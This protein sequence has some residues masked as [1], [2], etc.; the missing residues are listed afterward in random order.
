[1]TNP[2]IRGIIFDLDGVI[3]DTARLHYQSWLRLA[4]EENVP[5]TWET[6][7][8]MSGTTRENNLRV[9]TQGLAL[10]DATK[11]RWFE[12]KN[13]YFV[14]MMH[15]LRPGDALPGVERIMQQARAA[16]L[17]IGVGSSSRNALP[18]LRLLGLLDQFDVIGD[19][20]SVERS[21]PAPDIFLWVAGA[22]G[23]PPRHVL[24]LEDAP[25]GVE[26]ARTGGFYVIGLG[27]VPL[28]DAHA[29]L[30]GLAD[31]HLPDLL[32]LLTG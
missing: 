24:V 19:G 8:L 20:D 29:V 4:Q 22:L 3:A 17:K 7:L 21:K 18:V 25:A 14:E 10:D 2:D 30:P 16:H 6:Y 13:S 11:K 31:S 12:R 15:D 32:A 26:A 28:P 23:L 1:M 27:H 9:F 5:F